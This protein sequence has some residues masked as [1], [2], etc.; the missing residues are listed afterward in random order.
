MCSNKDR[1]SL[2][3]LVLFF[4]AT[5]AEA[6]ESAGFVSLTIGNQFFDKSIE[7]ARTKAEQDESTGVFGLRFESRLPSLTWGVSLDRYSNDW[8][9][10]VPSS[11]TDGTYTITTVFG[12]IKGS[13]RIYRDIFFYG[14]GGVGLANI[15]SHYSTNTA[16]SGGSDNR[17][18]RVPTVKG[19]LGT[20]WRFD[21]SA[22]YVDVQLIAIGNAGSSGRYDHFSGSVSPRLSMG[23]GFF[24]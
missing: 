15:D 19:I 23:V 9:T 5:I 12:E 20:E 17:E 1:V 4:F 24:Y 21:T 16:F 22:I 3:A 13:L 2:S 14:G 7:V 11:R 10:S 6:S 18:F 8:K